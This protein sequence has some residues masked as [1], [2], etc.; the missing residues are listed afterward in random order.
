MS[1]S[2]N[3]P[4]VTKTQVNTEV[5]NALNTAIPG[6]PASDSINER[7][8][9]M[10]GL[11]YTMNSRITGTV[12]TLTAQNVEDEA[13]DGA[14]T[15]LNT[16]ISGSNTAD[17]VNDILHD[18]LKP[19]LPGSGTISTLTAANIEDQCD[20]SLN[21]AISSPAANS[22]AGILE[23]LNKGTK[24]DFKE[25]YANILIGSSGSSGYNSVVDVDNKV[26][27]LTSIDIYVPNATAGQQ[28]GA[29]ATL[30]VALSG[31]TA[32]TIELCVNG[33]FSI[34]WLIHRDGIA[35]AA[36]GVADHTRYHFNQPFISTTNSLNVGVTVT[37]GS[38]GGEM[39]MRVLY[40]QEI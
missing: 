39:H 33:T 17:S 24:V 26:G 6:S 20:N 15:A 16:E 19:R 29:T 22:A 28:A 37:P 35:S 8:A 27:A 31:G 7:I 34:N 32:S 1:V 3:I 36:A 12:S 11:I 2:S 25:A 30:S 5:D 9:T 13:E 38:A 14:L 23:Q 18:Q 21:N 40:A 10:D 4:K